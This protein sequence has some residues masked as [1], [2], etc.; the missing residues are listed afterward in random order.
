M[1]KDAGGDAVA[2]LVL[3]VGAH[4]DAVG[5]VPD[6]QRRILALVRRGQPALVRAEQ[7]RAEQG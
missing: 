7:Y 2:N 6:N 5:G 4:G 1:A 3:K